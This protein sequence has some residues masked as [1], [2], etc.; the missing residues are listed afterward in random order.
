MRTITLAL[1]ALCLT[2]SVLVLSGCRE[3][4]R[5]YAPKNPTI[6]QNRYDK[7]MDPMAGTAPIFP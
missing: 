1:A 3:E 5:D 2:A 6:Q 4:E 7:T